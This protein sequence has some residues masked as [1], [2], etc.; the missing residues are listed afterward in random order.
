MV[1]Q[2]IEDNIMIAKFDNP[3]TY[4]MTFESLQIIRDAVKKVNEDPSLKG[5]IFTGEGKFFCSGFDLPTF[6]SFKNKEDVLRFF[7]VEEEMLYE[8]F[9]CTKPVV[10]AINGH[11]TAGGFIVAMGCDYRI[12]TDNPKAKMGMTETK[13]GLSLTI[14]EMELVRYGC[15]DYK[16]LRNILYDGERHSFE[17]AKEMGIIDQIV[18]EA[19]LI[20]TAKKRICYWW[21]Q[22]GHAFT[23]L[24][25]CLKYP[26]ASQIR[27][28]L[29]NENWQ[30][31][32]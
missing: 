8:I 27:Y 6:L 3:P 20:E 28:R 14:A 2:I 12:A 24:K 25:Y 31:S 1:K 29:D 16:T 32:L 22:P 18:P 30:D 9:T 10:A 23:N 17:A 21:D 5:L 19:E 11:C 4:S 7:N 15:N 13:I 26:I